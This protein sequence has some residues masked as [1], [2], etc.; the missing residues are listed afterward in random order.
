MATFLETK[1]QSYPFEMNNATYTWD[2]ACEEEIVINLEECMIWATIAA[3]GMW[4]NNLY[5]LQRMYC[6]INDATIRLLLFLLRW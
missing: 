3:S 2:G 6:I 5:F 4:T 1:H